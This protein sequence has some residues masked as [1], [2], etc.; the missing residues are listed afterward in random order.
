MSKKDCIFCKIANKELPAEIIFES[1]NVMVFHD[2]TPQAPLHLLIIT[3]KHYESLNEIEDTALLGELLNAAK[4]ITKKMGI[5]EYR[6]VI[7]TGKQAGQTIFHAHVHL[8]AK[9]KMLWP[10]G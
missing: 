2:L 8:L 3:K 4:L 1:E 10:P 5:K 9:R 7:N 6:T